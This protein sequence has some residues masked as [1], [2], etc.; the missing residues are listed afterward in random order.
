MSGGGESRSFRK[1]LN[2][3]A[4]RDPFWEDSKLRVEVWEF[5]ESQPICVSS[6]EGRCKEHMYST[7]GC[8]T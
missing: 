8:M 5:I 3:E 6:D 7:R 4:L 2:S 1:R